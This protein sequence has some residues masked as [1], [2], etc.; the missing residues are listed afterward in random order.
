MRCGGRIIGLSYTIGG[1][2]GGWQPWVGMGSAKAAM[3]SISRYFAVAVGRFGITVNTV[4]PGFSDATTVV[5]QTPQEWQSAMMQWVESGW[6]PMRQ[7]CTPPDIAG[8]CALLC[9][10]EAR[11]MTGQALTVDGGASLMNPH[12]PLALQVPA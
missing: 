4:S 1:R 2:T 6:T 7:R 5:G 12:F 8:V 11:F 9:S 3:E 10:D